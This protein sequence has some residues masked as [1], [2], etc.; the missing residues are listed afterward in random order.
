MTSGLLGGRTHDMSALV[1]RVFSSHHVVAS[2]VRYGV[3]AVWR[4]T[5]EDLVT[6]VFARVL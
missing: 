3:H 6:D 5:H 4:Q 2:V 1:R